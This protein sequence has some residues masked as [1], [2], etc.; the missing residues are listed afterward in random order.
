MSQRKSKTGHISFEVY[1]NSTFAK[2]II[3][4]ENDPLIDFIAIE[5]TR[6]RRPPIWSSSA[7]ND[8]PDDSF[9]VLRKD[10]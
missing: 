8:V 4:K 9:S 3:Q 6:S 10:E 1:F 7:T 2:K 5:A